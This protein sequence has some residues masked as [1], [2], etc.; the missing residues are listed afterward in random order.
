MNQELKPL[1]EELEKERKDNL[2]L[3]TQGFLILSIPYFLT[4]LLSFNASSTFLPIFSTILFLITA[5]G[6][7]FYIASKWSKTFKEKFIGLIVKSLFP[8]LNFYPDKFISKELFL[9]SRLFEDYPSP[10][11]YKGE[12][13][14]EGKI[15]DIKIKSSWI[16]A[17]YESESYDHDNNTTRT[18]YHTIFS[19]IFVIA[20][21]N[22]RFTSTTVILPKKFIRISPKKLKRVRLED[23]EFESLFDVFTNDQVEARYILTPVF[24]EKVKSFKKKVGNEIRLSFIDST[25]YVAIRTKQKLLT[26]PSLF[27]SLHDYNLEAATKRYEEEIKFMVSIVEE[28]N[29]NL[30]LY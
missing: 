11:V 29:L 17:K 18:T 1:I 14:I 26:S 3:V 23:P 27:D 9:K 30:K 7:Y 21:F 2:T 13:L 19:G 28:F 25:I 4:L 20:D 24:M 8:D 16:E 5:L 6:V 15:G 10:D 12:N 22:K